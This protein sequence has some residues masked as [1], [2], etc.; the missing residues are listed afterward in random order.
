MN[1]STTNISPNLA[2]T[3]ASI[4]QFT[5]LISKT[6]TDASP[7]AYECALFY[8]INT[9]TA[10]VT[11]GTI[12]QTITSTFLNNSATYSQSSDDDLIYTPHPS[13]TNN[14]SSNTTTF[15]VSSLAALALNSFIKTSFTGYGRISPLPLPLPPP[16][17]IA[18]KHPSSPQTQSTPSTPRKI[19]LTEYPTSLSP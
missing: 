19:T 3:T 16:P 6:D 14:T 4:I 17:T 15:T 18:T 9:Y 13:F 11:D 7:S 5:S 8:C 12:S 1:S 2:N 10:S